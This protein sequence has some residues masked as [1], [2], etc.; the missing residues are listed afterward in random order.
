MN[1]SSQKHFY[2]LDWF[3][4]LAAFEVMEYHARA[5]VWAHYDQLQT[6]SKNCLTWVFFEATHWGGQAVI[7][8]FVLSGFLVGGKVLERSLDRSFDLQAYVLDRVTRIYVPLLPVLVV[9]G[10]VGYIIGGQPIS[11]SSLL[12]NLTALQSVCARSYGG[13]LPLWSLSYESWFYVL[14]GLGAVL[15]CG[16]GRAKMISLCGMMFVLA[17]FTRLQPWY[18]FC[19]LLG[20]FS[21][22]LVL[23]EVL[24]SLVFAGGVAMALFGLGFS[25]YISAHQRSFG[26][27]LSSGHVAYMIFSLGVALIFP[28]VARRVPGSA[29]M[30]RCERIGG[31][32]A[33]FSYTLYLTHYPVT[34]LWSK[35]RPEKFTAVDV[36]SL[37]WFI[38]VSLSCLVFAYVLYLPFE[39]QTSRVRGWLKQ[40][41][42][43]RDGTRGRGQ[44]AFPARGIAAATGPAAKED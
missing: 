2:W 20:A 32:L 11:I 26:D 27:F 40:R 4:F 28:F 9:S 39:A 33:A 13:N 1:S 23:A 38:V 16:S 10:I 25:E 18:L 41:V 44:G 35:F 42:R 8:F 17:L 37:F 36:H 6:N 29:A 22:L 21:Y 7:L 5:H 12:G 24:P 3:R 19:W 30:R 14:G 15:L 43:G 34:S 31:K